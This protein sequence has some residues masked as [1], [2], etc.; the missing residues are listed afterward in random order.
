MKAAR[1]K[2][3]RLK[4]RFTRPDLLNAQHVSALSREPL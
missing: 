1:V 3:A 4:L 2:F